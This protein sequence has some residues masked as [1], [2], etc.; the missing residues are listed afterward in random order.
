VDPENYDGVVAA[1]TLLDT[2]LDTVASR[3]PMPKE[4]HDSL[5]ECVQTVVREIQQLRNITA[6]LSPPNQLARKW[7]LNAARE[8]KKLELKAKGI[9]MDA[10]LYDIY[11][12]PN[13]G[14]VR[15]KISLEEG[16]DLS[17]DDDDSTRRGLDNGLGNATTFGYDDFM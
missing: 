17:D 16:L 11:P 14:M 4:W 2:D 1:Q 8:L 13:P 12:P 15:N 6:P 5:V 9:F 3:L 10:A 7:L